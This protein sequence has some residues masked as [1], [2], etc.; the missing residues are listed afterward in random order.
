MRWVV[1]MA[2]AGVLAG[3]ATQAPPRTAVHRAGRPA[4]STVSKP[5]ATGTPV[6]LDAPTPPPEGPGANAPLEGF[7]PMRN[8]S[9]P[10]A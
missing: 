2:S 3:C 9:R 5:L 6:K 7:R 10:G 4:V 8:Q 1:A